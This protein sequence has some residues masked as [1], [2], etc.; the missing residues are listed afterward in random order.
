MAVQVSAIGILAAGSM[1][2]PDYPDGNRRVV[3]SLD[4]LA[5]SAPRTRSVRQ[6]DRTDYGEI[7]VNGQCG[8]NVTRI[9]VRATPVSGY[10]GTGT[11][12]QVIDD[13]PVNGT[14][15][16]KLRLK[17]GWYDLN[18]IAYTGTGRVIV[19]TGMV[20]RVGVGEVF[21][22]AGQSNSANYGEPGLKAAD[23]RISS[24]DLT[25]N[26]S[27]AVSPLPVASGNGGSPWPPF[28]DELAR[29]LDVP[30]GVI[31][32]GVGSTQVSQWVPGAAY[33]NRIR[34]ALQLLGTNGCRAV[35]WHQGESD[36]SSGTLAS[37]YA[38]R[39][40]S[41]ITQSR[42]DAGFAVPW[43]VAIASWLPDTSD[44]SALQVQAGQWMVISNTPGVFKG[45]ETDSFHLMGYLY[46][47][48]HFNTNGLKAHGAQWAEIV[49]RYA[50]PKPQSPVLVSIAAADSNAFNVS[51]NV[52]TNLTCELQYAANLADTPLLWTS[53]GDWIFTSNNSQTVLG[54]AAGQPAGFYRI[55][56]PHTDY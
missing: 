1:P 9:A 41:I 53:V 22:T 18:F 13:A 10:T 42:L 26:W 28:G 37:D 43:G 46:D 16:G 27:H 38:Q 48:I 32:L 17:G 2:L 49:R 35:L 23:D 12:W 30:V 11:G 15:A 14:F 33:Y 24:C 40:Q 21:V 56:F 29:L 54:A 36:G 39:L 31:S 34:D 51:W 4:S 47:G 55:V 52:E 19:A 45:A 50:F 44:A 6:R 25:G 8:S 3:E 20:A 5:I 7:G